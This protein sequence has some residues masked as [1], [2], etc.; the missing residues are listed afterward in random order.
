[1]SASAIQNYY[2]ELEKINQHGGDNKESAIRSAFHNLL[3]E[4][5]RA[6]GFVLVDELEY[7]NT[8]NYPDG[9]IKDGLRLDWGYWEAKDEDDDLDKEISKKFA[10]GYP[11]DNIIFEDSQTAVLF[12]AG[13]EVARINMKNPDEL[14]KILKKLLSYKRPEILDFELAI[15]RFSSDIPQIVKSLRELIKHAESNSDFSKNQKQFLELCRESIN[16]QMTTEDVQEML[17]QHIL[18]EEIFISVF[19]ESQFHRENNIAKQLLELEN[20]F[21]FGQTKRELLANLQSYYKI[22]KARA[23]QISDHHEKQKFLKLIYENFYK[24]YNPD[25]ADTLGVVYTPNEIV[26]FIIEG[27]QFLSNMHFGKFLEDEN[28]KILDPATGTGTF[29]T[30]L[31]DYLPANKLEYKYQ[32]ELFCNEIAVLPYYVANLNIEF[33]YK[34]KM[35][36]YLEFTNIALVDTLDNI[37]FGGKYANA[38]KD[39]LFGGVSLEN[40]LRIQRQNDQKISIIMGNPPYNANQM[41]FNS[42]NANRVYE[43]V[44]SRIKETS[45]QKTKVY[46]MY[47]RFF[48]WAS[49]R[50]DTKGIVA[51]VTNS[52]FVTSRTF[53][54]FRKSVTKEFNYIYIVDCGG[55]VRAGET[56]G[57]VFDI[58]TGVAIC[59][60]VRTE[61]DPNLPDWSK[62]D[63]K[64]NRTLYYKLEAKGKANKLQELSFLSQQF[65]RINFTAKTIDRKGNWLNQ[66]TNDWDEL[67]PLASKKEKQADGGQQKEKAIFDLYSNGVVTNRDYW[68]YDLDKHNLTNKAKFFIQEYNQSIDK[69]KKGIPLLRGGNEVDGVDSVEQTKPNQTP[70]QKL[71]VG[72]EVL[73]NKI[74]WSHT[75][76]A[77]LKAGKKAKFDKTKIIKSNYRPF[78]EKYYYNEK[79]FSDRLT[80]NHYDIFGEN[81]DLDNV[82]IVYKIGKDSESYFFNSKNIQDLMTNGGN[83]LF[84]QYRYHKTKEGKLLKKDNIT[85]W[86]LELFKEKYKNSPREGWTAKQDGVLSNS[87][88]AQSSSQN[89]ELDPKPITKTD[90]FYYVYGVLH[91]PNYRTKYQNEL[92]RDFPRIP[93]YEDFWKWSELGKKLCKMHLGETEV[94]NKTTQIVQIK[95]SKNLSPNLQNPTPILK[96]DKIN[97][98]IILDSHTKI[99][100]IPKTA[101]DYK[102]GNR[103]A[104]EWILEQHKPAKNTEQA[105][106]DFDNYNWG[107]LK[108]QIIE[109]LEKVIWISEKTVEIIGDTENVVGEIDMN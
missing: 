79:L 87:N 65:A 10:K 32:N 20:T 66:T 70:I 107:T 56:D 25:K 46:D 13:Q 47:S 37:Y 26:K 92:K 101:W 24:H 61:I 35:G 73:S 81:L 72:G 83:V 17:I 58:M 69:Y 108:P 53:D 23:S 33:T 8:R 95:T 36:K 71:T 28:V 80:Q 30:E 91:D 103:S 34:Q 86:A 27:C 1:M 85:D 18:T 89:K 109:T 100:N 6:K 22:I 4:Y 64:Q 88:Q 39:D 84:P 52:S 99:V 44:D 51:F 93:F 7:K 106:H 82:C 50:I 94:K 75:L 96:A 60:L 9:T 31:I 40:S 104:V 59:F 74:K 102:L 12:Q 48:R 38:K 42:N 67:T 41:N 54:G 55:N 57:N 19:D 49:D 29:I 21:F 62:Y 97:G 98:E 68:V 15:E 76:L 16:P 43:K 14:D 11:N 63:K 78:V 90:I 45:A 77:N 105:K 2:Q 3:N 5:S